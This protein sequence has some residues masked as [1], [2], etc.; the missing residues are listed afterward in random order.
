MKNTLNFLKPAS[1]AYEGKIRL[2]VSFVMR[3]QLKEYRIWKTFIRPYFYLS[4]GEDNGWRGEYWGKAMRGACLI[5]NYNEDPQLYEVLRYAVEEL[6]K[7]QDKDGRLSSYEKDVEFRGWDLWCRKYVLTGLLHFYEICKEKNLK[8]EVYV[9][10]QRHADYIVSKI[11]EG[12][13]DIRTTSNFWGGTNSCSILEPFVQ[14]Y[15]LTGKPEYL[16]FAKYIISTGGCL[17]GDL[18]EF[19][20]KED[21]YPYQY[22]EQKAY[23]TMSFF[24]GILAYYEATDEEQYLNVVKKFV[25][26]VYSSD[27]TII[28]CAGCSGELFDNSAVAQTKIPEWHMQETCVTVTWM[29]LLAR[30]HLL[31]GEKKYF[32]RMEI[33]AVNAMAG[34]VNI[35][36]QKAYVL[37][38]KKWLAPLPFDSYSPLV[39]SKR[40]LA[41]GG[42]KPLG[43]GA[44]YGCCACIGSAGV[45]VYPLSCVLRSEKGVF[46][47]AYFAGK[48]NAQT[49]A[50]K[51]ITF[52]ITGDYPTSEEIKILVSC[53]VSETFKL[54]LRVPDWCEEL[55]I[56]A[57]GLT[58]VDEG[59]YYTIEKDWKGDTMLKLSVK[60]IIKP[61]HLN[62]KTAYVYG[63]VVLALDEGKNKEKTD[64][65]IVLGE[66]EFK[67]KWERATPVG[68]ERIR[69]CLTA[70]EGKKYIFTD[71]AS[72]GKK[73]ETHDDKVSVWLDVKD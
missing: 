24:E 73:W 53:P 42:Y 71:Y 30:L 63:A 7:Y 50:G 8:E 3:K 40:G 10:M 44:Y 2:Y 45:A 52:E 6:L 54:Y 16:D 29:R 19:A 26:D 34:S 61:V 56:S 48:V 21:V 70:A 72:C 39:H 49:P 67:D 18:L 17:D 14:L 41:T 46:L 31:T 37:E 32:D 59:G 23:E 15:K 25:E 4:D 60:T 51:R 11:G 28:G 64:E 69:F 58:A 27:I 1:S 9:A 55:G 62:G 33:S 13:I 20:R 57:D 43:D 22:P 36:D 12:K 5:Y 38:V 66:G 35:Y 65:E 68:N 47:N